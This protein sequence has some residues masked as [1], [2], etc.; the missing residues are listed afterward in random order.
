MPGRFLPTGSADKEPLPGDRFRLN[1][2]DSN[3][4]RGS[5]FKT[6]TLFQRIFLLTK[7]TTKWHKKITHRDIN[8]PCDSIVDFS[9]AT[10]PQ[11]VYTEGR[12]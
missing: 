8:T 12:T 2:Y 9:G 5:G 10:Q 6:G 7:Y 3:E 4:T 11:S 1:F